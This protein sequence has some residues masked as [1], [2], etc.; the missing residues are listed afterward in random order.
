MEDNLLTWILSTALMAVFGTMGAAV[1]SL[2]LRLRAIEREER[3]F[4]ICVAEN[5]VR[6]DDYVPQMSG[7][8]IRLDSIGTMVARI[9]E[10]TRRHSE[11]PPHES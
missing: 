5:Y 7:V 3:D 6:R 11:T 8:N 1:R 2:F 4:R 10:R 9:D